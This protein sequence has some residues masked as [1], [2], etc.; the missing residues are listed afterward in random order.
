MWESWKRYRASY[1]V[2][3]IRTRSESPIGTNPCVGSRRTGSENV[4]V[5]NRTS[6]LCLVSRLGH[7]LVQHRGQVSEWPGT[8]FIPSENINQWSEKKFN[9]R[10]RKV[11][12]LLHWSYNQYLLGVPD[13]PGSCVGSRRTDSDRSNLKV[14]HMSRPRTESGLEVRC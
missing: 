11:L 6:V 4:L 2:A 1:T 12:D 8:E 14:G 5:R 7:S 3:T 9:Y 13:R 10:F